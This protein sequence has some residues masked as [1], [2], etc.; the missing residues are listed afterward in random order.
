MIKIVP[1]DNGSTDFYFSM[2]YQEEI[3]KSEDLKAILETIDKDIWD[4]DV[5]FTEEVDNLI[6]E[7]EEELPKS[8]FQFNK[9]KN[10]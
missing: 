3:Y 7:L 10:L 4:K 2:A 6:R 5:P 8:V 1:P 9:Y